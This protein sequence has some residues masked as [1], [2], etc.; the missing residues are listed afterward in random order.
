[1]VEN[2]VRIPLALRPAATALAA[3]TAPPPETTTS[4]AP[5][6]AATFAERI[7]AGVPPL[8]WNAS[9]GVAWWDAFV[10]GTPKRDLGLPNN[11]VAR[12]LIADA[13]KGSGYTVETRDYSPAPVGAAVPGVIHVVV[14]V[15]P[16]RDPTHAIAF[17][18]H[19]DTQGGTIYGAY[20]NG[21]GAAAVV[22]T[23]D[24]L[25]RVATERT[26]LCL[27]FDGEEEGTL[28]SQAFMDDVAASHEWTLDLYVGFDMVGL[29][30]PGMDPGPEGTWRLFGWVGPEYAYD[31]FPFV[32]ETFTRV[33]DFPTSGAE[34][35][36]FNDRNS[37]E[38]T[39]KAA[40]V[41]TLRLAGGRTAGSYPQYHKPGD[42]VAYVDSFAGGR[43]KYEAGFGAVVRTAYTTALAFDATSLEGIRAAH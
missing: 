33:L 32:N 20:D 26:I 43:S 40:H 39:F 23:C 2:R 27:L 13:L 19:F 4:P 16:G 35:F 5:Q 42:T 15:K 38:A 24:A 14:G 1:M 7:A 28:G 30:W 34:V 22:Q 11:A 25:A 29:N 8:A 3:C 36:P 6:D 21:S 10:S 18:G 37:D 31:L 12:G 17:G 41:P 9:K